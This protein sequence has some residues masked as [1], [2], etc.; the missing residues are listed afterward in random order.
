[1]ISRLPGGTLRQFGDD[2]GIG[3]DEV[4]VN[5]FNGGG[6]ASWPRGYLIMIMVFGS[7][8]IIKCAREGGL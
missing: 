8:V 6:Q 2:I 5:R 1:M 7:I 4:E 3:D